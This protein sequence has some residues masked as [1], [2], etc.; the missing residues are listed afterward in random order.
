MALTEAQLRGAMKFQLRNFRQRDE[1]V[2]DRTVHSRI[3][4]DDDGT[5]T[6]TSKRIYK[7][8]IRWTIVTHGLP[9]R[10]WPANWMRMRVDTLAKR[11]L[12][13]E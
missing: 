5:G 12:G 6:A 4:S 7:A 10:P 1:P 2:T 3:L 8:L 11:L 9:D 13:I